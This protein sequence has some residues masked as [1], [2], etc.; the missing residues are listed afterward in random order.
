MGWPVKLVDLSNGNKEMR[1]SLPYKVVVGKKKSRQ[2]KT[3]KAEAD[4]YRR[5]LRVVEDCLLVNF[6]T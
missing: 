1:S 3:L 6:M 2:R 5:S 4:K